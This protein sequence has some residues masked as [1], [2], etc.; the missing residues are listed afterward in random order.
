MKYIKI[1][2]ILLLVAILITA[3]SP[4]QATLKFSDVQPQV[5]AEN[6]TP[7]GTQQIEPAATA[8]QSETTDTDLTKSDSQGLVTVEITPLNLGK[9]GENLIFTVSMN[10]HSVDLSMDLAKLSVLS[11]DTG[12]TIPA[13]QWE[14]PSGGHHVEGKLVFPTTLD[15]KNLF[16]GAQSFTISIINVDAP[17]RTFSWQ[18]IK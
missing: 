14:A 5:T 8:S 9:Q 17:L 13:I 10:T 2:L 15:G 1:I 12:K 11:T 3:C 16:E 4:T 18:L 6:P 7:A